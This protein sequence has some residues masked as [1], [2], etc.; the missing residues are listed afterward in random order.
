M[1]TND[2]LLHYPN[3]PLIIVLHSA[4]ECQALAQ[5]SKSPEGNPRALYKQKPRVAIKSTRGG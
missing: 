4:K 5:K 1:L 2:P 3:T